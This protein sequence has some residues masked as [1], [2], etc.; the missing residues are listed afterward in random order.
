MPAV[1][2]KDDGMPR[3]CLYQRPNATHQGC[4]HWDNH[5]LCGQAT[6]NQGQCISSVGYLTSPLVNEYVQQPISLSVYQNRTKKITDR[7][8]RLGEFVFG[9]ADQLPQLNGLQANRSLPYH[10]ISEHP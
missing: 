7:E 1:V 6:S 2:R 3:R 5:G 10:P 4:R 9:F 8:R